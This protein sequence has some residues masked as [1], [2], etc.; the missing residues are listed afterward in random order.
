[1]TSLS[2]IALVVMCGLAYIWL[3]RGFFSSLLHL[4]CTI[5]AGAIAFAAWEP[6]SYWLLQSSPTSG[7]MSF[8]AGICWGVG[9]I[10]PFAV[11][12]ALLRLI[13]D[14]LLPANVV[15]EQKLDFIGGAVCGLGSG[16]ITAGLLCIALN[17]FRLG[18]DTPCQP[19]TYGSNGNLTRT[20]HLWVPLD[21]LTADL[22]GSLSE[23]AFRTGDPLARWHPDLSEE[24]ATMRLTCFEGRGRNTLKVEDFTVESRFTVGD[25]GKTPLKNLLQDRWNPGSNGAA[26]PQKIADLDG[27]AFPEGTHLEGVL[28]N[29]KAGAKERDG[30]I[31]VGAAQV[32]MILEDNNDDR[33]TVFPIA[34]SS[35]AEADKPTPAR[36]RYDAADTF[37][38]SIGAAANSPFAFEFP[39]PPNYRPIAVYVKGVR[40]IIDPSGPKPKN[41]A[42]SEERD[43]AIASGFGL[44]S[45]AS[46]KTGGTNLASGAVDTSEA[47]KLTRK[48]APGTNGGPLALPE[49]MRASEMLPFVLQKGQHG[50]LELDEE[51]NKNIILRGDCTVGLEV[52]QNRGLEKPIQI[53]RLQTDASTVIV[54]VDVSASSKMSILGKSDSSDQNAPPAFFDTNGTN[55]WPVGY[56]YQDETKVQVSFKPGDPITSMTKLPTLSRSRPAQKLILIFRVSRGVSLKYFGLGNKAMVAFDPPVLM[57][58]IQGRN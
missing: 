27:K 52:L 28:V 38:A 8:T 39:C 2:L 23:R 57:D 1:M 35:Q 14:K 46:G 4:T 53:Q 54:Q 40:Y 55:Y 12:L 9:L 16:A 11:S 17:F 3:T 43:S 42:T 24:G 47:V 34:V 6:L 13:V 33:M 10:V 51:N 41:Y 5:I 30:K 50:D 36:W 48:P 20:G 58:Q 49:G 44:L 56:I 32:R 15:L 26:N 25:G 21:T 22:Y 45:V 29:F 7:F 19:I 31:A 18:A 37:I